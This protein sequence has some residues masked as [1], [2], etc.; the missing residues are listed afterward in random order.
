[1][2]QERMELEEELN[3]ISIS[4]NGY[5]SS[6]EIAFPHIRIFLN[7]SLSCYTHR[8]QLPL[9]AQNLVQGKS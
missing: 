3:N 4:I 8:S 2:D 7:L 5:F 9:K 6:P 1:M